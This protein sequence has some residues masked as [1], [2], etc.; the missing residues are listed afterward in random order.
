ML[1]DV[2]PLPELDVARVRRWCDAQVPQNMRD[3]VRVE[4]EVAPRHLTIV[5]LHPPW[6]EPNDGEWMRLIVARLHYRRTAGTWHLYWA[7]RNERLHEY[8]LCAPSAHVEDL[9]RE[10]DDDPTCIFWG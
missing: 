3:R 1:A 7:D 8:D 4:C 6:E 2:P 10:I 9:L 5:E